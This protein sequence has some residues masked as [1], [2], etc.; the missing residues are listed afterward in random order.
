MRVSDS[1]PGRRRARRGQVRTVSAASRLPENDHPRWLIEDGRFRR[2][3][4]RRVVKLA[5]HRGEKGDSQLLM[6]CL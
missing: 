3:K 4:T 1:A 5:G 2:R 6:W